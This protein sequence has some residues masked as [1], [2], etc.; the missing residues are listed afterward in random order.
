MRKANALT[1]AN[2]MQA[3]LHHEALVR[4][5]IVTGAAL[6]LILAGQPLPY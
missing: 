5:V 2:G 1:I 3:A 6:A 4:T